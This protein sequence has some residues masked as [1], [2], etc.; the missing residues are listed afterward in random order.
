MAEDLDWLCSNWP[1]IVH[2]LIGRFGTSIGSSCPF[3][4]ALF[5]SWCNRYR[6]LLRVSSDLCVCVQCVC[7]DWTFG[8]DFIDVYLVVCRLELGQEGNAVTNAGW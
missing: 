2:R 5:E 6:F 8:L 7:V 1:P 3:G 4:A